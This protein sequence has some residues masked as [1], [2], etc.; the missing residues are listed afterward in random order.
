MQVL[1]TMCTSNKSIIFVVICRD[2]CVEFVYLVSFVRLFRR[3]SV[4]W[5]CVDYMHINLVA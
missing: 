3:C 5:Q 1:P 4:A 2:K